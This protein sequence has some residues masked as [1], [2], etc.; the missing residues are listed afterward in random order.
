MIF[1]IIFD[2][3]MIFEIIFDFSERKL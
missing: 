2:F 1:E 3:F